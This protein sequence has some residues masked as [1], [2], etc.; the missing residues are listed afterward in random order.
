M[1]EHQIINLFFQ[2]SEAAIT[3]LKETYG[4]LCFSVARRILSDPRDAEECFNDVLIKIWNS[5]PP[6]RPDSLAA[7][8]S[9][10]TR[11]T[12]LDRFSY[13]HAEKRSTALTDAFE[14]LEGSLASSFQVEQL[15]LDKD[16]YRFINEFLHNQ[17][18]QN[19]IFFVRRYWYGES[20]TEIAQALQ[21]S[22]E[23]VKSSLF[24]TRNRLKIALEK[25]GVS[26]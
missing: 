14:E 13:N 17:T 24:R 2:R 5:I 21:V 11:N 19:R 18:K 20:I 4:N 26:L 15:A 7:Y 10:I 16:F 23:K 6:E 1:E 12:A 8:V 3:H 22:E 9:R 25:E